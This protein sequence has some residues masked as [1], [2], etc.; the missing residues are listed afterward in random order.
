MIDEV[1]LYGDQEVLH[2]VEGLISE[3]H[4][5]AFNQSLKPLMVQ[6]L[7]IQAKFS[8][9]KGEFKSA[10]KLLEQAERLSIESGLT[11]LTTKLSE[12][13]NLLYSEM[14]KWSVLIQQNAPLNDRL[15]L[16]HMNDYISKALKLVP[17]D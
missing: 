5:I 12:E 14:E 2:Q 16:A 6:T 1:K 3:I 10:I 8:L 4:T 11:L 17:N 13:K 7:L 15:K 9:I